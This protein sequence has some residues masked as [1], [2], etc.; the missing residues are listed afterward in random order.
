MIS[1]AFTIFG[2]PCSGKNSREIVMPKGMERPLVIKSAKARN[3]VRDMHRQIPQHARQMFTGPVRLTVTAYYKDERSDLDVELIRDCL[4]PVYGP[5][6]NGKRELIWKG[7]ILND[8][9]VKEQHAYHRIDKK[10]PRAEIEV[11]ALVAQALEL[12]LRQIPTYDD[13]PFGKAVA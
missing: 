7:V 9:Q 3:Y 4:Q 10:N 5:K 13:V 2:E 6:I 11:V 12:E 1:T 8:R